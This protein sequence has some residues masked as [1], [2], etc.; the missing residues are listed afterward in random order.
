LRQSKYWYILN[1]NAEKY[2]KI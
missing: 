2:T 1:K